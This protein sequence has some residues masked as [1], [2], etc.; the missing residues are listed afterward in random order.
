MERVLGIGG[1]FFHAA[2]PEALSRW[3]A[4]H[5]GIDAPPPS[6]DISSW[7]QQG[8]ATVL[9]GL[10]ADSAHFPPG[11]TWSVTFRVRDL[12]AMIE[13]LQG[14]GVRVQRDDESYPNGVFA[15]L[16]DPEGNGIQLWEVAG[17]DA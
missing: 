7:R 10:S 16:E 4:E 17:A 11:R 1:L 5:L 3:Y 15:T 13:Q 6:Y 9:S 8:G 2:D 12:D 14:A